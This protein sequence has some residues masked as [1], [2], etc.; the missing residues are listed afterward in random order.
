VPLP[1]DRGRHGDARPKVHRIR[2]HWLELGR[3]L[4]AFRGRYALTQDEVAAVVGAK[5]GTALAQWENSANVPDGLR[6][7]RL[8]ELLEGRLWPELRALLIGGDGMPS[9]WTQG[10][11]WYRRVSR[12]RGRRDCAGAVVAAILD[13]LRELSSPEGLR[14]RYVERD[15]E[16]AHAL[17][18]Q[19][20]LGDA[21]RAD[22]RRIEDAAVESL[23]KLGLP[24][25][26]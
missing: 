20:G 3:R 1:D 17:A 23:A 13:D 14:L 26:R 16:W 4:R 6:R 10:V 9:R 15:G 7:E 25:I 11:R 2:R 21:C 12:E 8:T 18:N 22:L 5:E 19:R 24:Q